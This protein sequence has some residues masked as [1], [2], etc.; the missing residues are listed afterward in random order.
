MNYKKK[1]Q[2]VLRSSDISNLGYSAGGIP[3][4]PTV[5]VTNTKGFINRWHTSYNFNLSLKAILGDLYNKKGTNYIMK[6]ENITF[7]LN[8]TLAP[9]S[10]FENNKFFNI[11]IAFNGGVNLS[12]Y[13]SNLTT[14]NSESL[15]ASIRLPNCAQSYN[16]QYNSNELSFSTDPGA[17][18]INLSINYKDFLLNSVEPSH[19]NT[20]AIGHAQFI[21]SIYLVE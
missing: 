12:S 2:L 18:L 4:E 20:T 7:G 10:S 6:L 21:F 8:S 1:V 13:S 14:M 11:F 17:D 9:Y 16:F 5:D 19:T 15:L 3:N